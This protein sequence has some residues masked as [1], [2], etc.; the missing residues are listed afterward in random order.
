[1]LTVD[2]I[3]TRRRADVLHVLPLSPEE[4]VR[5]LDLATSFVDLA[6]AH[7]GI[8]RGPFLEILR[9]LVSSVPVTDALMARAIEKLVLDGCVFEE[10]APLDAALLRDDLFARATLARKNLAAGSSFD[11]QVVLAQVGAERGIPPDDVDRALFADLPEAHVLRQVD[12][13]GPRTLVD[14]FDTAQIQA[15]L[16]RAVRLNVR[17]AKA[18]PRI[19]RAIF[20]KL[21]FLRLLHRITPVQTGSRRGGF[22]IE[23][24]G[25]FS[26]FESA[27]K[28]GLQL[29]LAY[30]FLIACDDFSLEATLRWGKDRRPLRFTARGGQTGMESGNEGPE[31][32]DDLPPEV[33]TLAHQI[34][35][36]PD[37]KWHAEVSTQVL[38]LPGVGLCVPDLDLKHES[39]A[40]VH[41]EV[42]GFWSRD[43]VWK[44]IEL[45]QAGLPVPV[46]FAVSKHLRVSEQALPDEI[47]ARLYVYAKTLSAR[48]VIERAEATIRASPDRSPKP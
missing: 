6:R 14:G 11:R 43:A 37:Q 34:N 15:V 12:L 41:L 40:V 9:P 30:P 8:E 28:Y 13:P 42:M 20:R 26:L 39:G 17:I 47:P 29:A 16:L 44:R 31:S 4:R 35:E 27:T 24:D 38:D 45:V 1:M 23:I 22:D 33:A 46:V 2:L 48:G 3:R 7:I 10:A 32:F 5:A 25:P 36:A 18:S 19:V 21:K